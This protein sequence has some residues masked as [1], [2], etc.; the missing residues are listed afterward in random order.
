MNLL[1]TLSMSYFVNLLSRRGYICLIRN[2]LR[3]YTVATLSVAVALVLTLILQTL[4]KSTFFS[5]FFASVTFSAWYGGLESGL[6]ATILSVLASSFF[7]MPINNNLL[8]RHGAN[9][10]HLILF[11]LVALLVSS[12]YSKL[13]NARQRAETNLAKL[14]LSE[15]KY[16][17][18][19]DTA[20]EGIWLLNTHMQTEFINQQLAQMLGYRTEEISTRSFNEFIAQTS[21]AEIEK[22]IERWQYG[23][24]ERFDCCF[25]TKDGSVLWAIVSTTTILTSDGEFNGVLAMLTDITERKR[26]EIERALLLEREQASRME[27]EEA[28]RCKDEFLAML[29]HELRSPLNP[30]LGWAEILQGK[31]LNQETTTYA[32]KTIE[33]NARLQAKLIE[34]LLDVSRILQGKLHLEFYPVS[35]VSVIKAAIEVVRLAAEEKAI[36]LKLKIFDLELQVIELS[37]NFNTNDNELCVLGDSKRLQ[38]IVWNLLL[39]AVKFT[40]PRGRVDVEL[41]LASSNQS[42]A[43]ILVKDTGI[44][45]QP[46]LL[47]HIFEPFRQADNSTTKNFSG[48]GLGLAIVRNLVELHKGT[49][50]VHSLGQGQGATFSVK[51]PLIQYRDETTVNNNLDIDSNL[52]SSSSILAGLKILVVD[53]EPDTRELLVFMLKQYGAIVTATASALQALKVLTNSEQ[54]LLLSDIGMPDINGYMLM[55]QIRN[56][57]VEQ[58]KQIPAIALTGYAR[59]LEKEEAELAGF[60]KIIAKPVKQDELI[61]AI[62]N[63]TGCSSK[64]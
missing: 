40:P 37:D 14:Q 49:V 4:L 36:N 42:L 21:Y 24:T 39:N 31:K 46:E 56:G 11:S 22:I 7:L 48:L 2:R 53:D 59:N 12:L 16:H 55:R 61:T 52:T 30:I 54:N 18:I 58:H 1:K 20:N 43:E 19:V 51:L 38:Q 57:K 23:G 27:A 25:Y 8:I 15:E 28:N 44:G 47:P 3:S 35:L 34:D 6:L 33:S 5:I 62:S 45:I 17:C 63:I 9:F 50:E 26:I 13:H 41:N 29:S 60:D 32:L 64:K 10:L